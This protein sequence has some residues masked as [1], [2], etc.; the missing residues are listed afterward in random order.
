MNYVIFILIFIIA[1]LSYNNLTKS[2]SFVLF[3]Y[4]IMPSSMAFP[5]SVFGISFVFSVARSFLLGFI[6]A[7]IGNLVSGRLK[8]KFIRTTCDKI[9]LFLILYLFLSL[10]WGVNLDYDLKIIFSEPWLLGFLGYFISMNLFI[11]KIIFLKLLKIIF[12]AIIIISF[13]GFL[14][15][16]TNKTITSFPIISS[17]TGLNLK[18][19]EYIQ[20][21]IGSRGGYA[22][23]S[24]TFWNNIIYGIA[25]TVFYPFFLILR[26][27]MKGKLLNLTLI[28]SS[29]AGILTVSRTAWF[30]VFYAV[31]LNFKKYKALFIGLTVIFFLVLL[32][33]LKTSFKED[34]YIDSTGYSIKSREVVLFPVLYDLQL[35]NKILFGFGIG[36][37]IYAR[38]NVDNEIKIIRLP[39]D[40]SFAQQ[41]FTIG[42]IGNILFLLFFLFYYFDL[43]K[44]TNKNDAFLFDIKTATSQMILIQLT[45]FFVSNSLFQ[46]PRLSFVFF[47]VL[48]AVK[49]TVMS[50]V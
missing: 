9:L 6:F 32:P 49:G 21:T 2:Y 22:R 26:K 34:G 8:I 18:T 40:N 35:Q 23:A 4:L 11:N 15:I 43:R 27:T 36:S 33:F 17:L 28:I 38:Q 25:L 45:L 12:I 29:I 42:V 13:Y 20:T 48:G 30:S 10:S 24:G 50:K 3:L 14:E 31:G 47:S 41:I 19:Y 39:G 1:I 46:D 44:N 37:Y 7:F 5:F 16:I